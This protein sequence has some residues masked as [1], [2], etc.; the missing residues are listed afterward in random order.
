MPFGP[1]NLH[2]AFTGKNVTH[3]G[4]VSLLHRFLRRLKLKSLFS[5]HVFFAQRNHHDTVSEVRCALIDPIALGC[6]RLD[7]THLLRH[8]GVF[9]YLTGLPAYPDPQTLRRFLLRMAPRSL[10]RLRRLHDKLLAT[11]MVRPVAPRRLIFD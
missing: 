3:F 2:I 6:G 8:N 1:R 10:P 4:G 7:T 5:R 11:M 9:Q